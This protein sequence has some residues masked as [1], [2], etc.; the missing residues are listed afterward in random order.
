MPTMNGWLEMTLM[1]S[2]N[3]EWAHDELASSV[4]LF[5]RLE[6]DMQAVHTQM[7]VLAIVVENLKNSWVAISLA[8][9]A[10]KIHTEDK[11]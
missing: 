10:F 11:R 8:H 2:N 7:Q 1:M 9:R 3:N 6:K 4:Y 5:Q